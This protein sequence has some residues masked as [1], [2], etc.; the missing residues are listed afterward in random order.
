MGIKSHGWFPEG[1]VL[2][3]ADKALSLLWF[4]TE[5]P[6]AL[7]YVLSFPATWC[8]LPFMVWGFWPAFITLGNS[9]WSATPF[10][11]SAAVVQGA[12][13]TAFAAYWYVCTLLTYVVVRAR[14]PL[15]ETS[16]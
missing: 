4:K 10:A 6:W 11:K 7:E 1:G 15:S 9:P 2:D 13:A 12:M 16:L 14:V 5:L 8:G 3:R